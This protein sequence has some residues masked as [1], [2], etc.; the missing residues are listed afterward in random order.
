MAEAY[1]VK[2]DVSLPRAI[3][4]LYDDSV[5]RQGTELYQTEGRSYR[6]GEYVLA[7]DITPPLRKMAADGELDHLLEPVDYDEAVEV[8][9][10]QSRYGR[11]RSFTP[12]HATEAHALKLG[13]HEVVETELETV[14]SED[15]GPDP[16]TE[17]VLKG[18]DE[19]PLEDTTE[20]RSQS[21]ELE[22]KKGSGSKKSA[23]KKSD[24]SGEKSE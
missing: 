13:G 1:K 21:G 8:L 18:A 16:S 22:S 9:R 7:E 2:Q 24:K 20:A 10:T 4:P 14:V 19:V 3:R 12:E 6:V 11:V 17:Q 15:A 5:A 23:S